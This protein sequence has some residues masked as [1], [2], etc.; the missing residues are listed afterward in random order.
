MQGGHGTAVE[1]ERHPVLAGIAVGLG[2]VAE[3]GLVEL[4]DGLR[5]RG[6]QLVP[7]RRAM[8]AVQGGARVCGRLPQ[9]EHGARRVGHDRHAAGVAGV[10]R[11]DAHRAPAAADRLRGHIRVVGRQIRR[12]CGRQMPVD[13]QPPD[14]RDLIAVDQ[15]A[16]VR[17]ELLRPGS[18]LPAEQLAVESLSRLKAVHHQADPAGCAGR[19][20]SRLGHC[21]LSPRTIVVAVRGNRMWAVV[22]NGRSPQQML[23]PR[24]VRRAP[25]APDLAGSRWRMPVL[26]RHIRISGVTGGPDAARGWLS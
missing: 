16:D 1:A 25:A 24:S 5:L 13:G 17:A 26:R 6:E 2:L 21:L 14:A 15:G 20:P 9:T 10:Q 11:A 8:C 12:P 18:E 19:V 3:D 7:H 23:A 22:R 4:R